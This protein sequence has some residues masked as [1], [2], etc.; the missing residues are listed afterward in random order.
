MQ[1]VGREE[2]NY[3]R[4]SKNLEEENALPVELGRPHLCTE[5]EPEV[6]CHLRVPSILPTT[7]PGLGHCLLPLVMG[8]DLMV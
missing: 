2:A 5:P 4:V 7:V 1:S 3:G 8:S 6:I